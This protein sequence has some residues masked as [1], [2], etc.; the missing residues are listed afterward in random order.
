M[1]S[2]S[3]TYITYYT[4]EELQRIV[5]YHTWILLVLNVGHACLFSYFLIDI[6]PLHL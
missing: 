2:T 4:L 6:E 1:L 5:S 3:C